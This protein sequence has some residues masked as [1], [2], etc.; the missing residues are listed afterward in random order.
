M[1]RDINIWK[2]KC[3]QMTM[4]DE[5]LIG[6]VF[7]FISSQSIFLLWWHFICF[8]SSFESQTF[9]FFFC[10]FSLSL[11]R[12]WRVSFIFIEGVT[13]ASKIE[14]IWKTTRA[15]TMKLFHTFLR[16]VHSKKL[17]VLLFLDTHTQH[18]LNFY[19]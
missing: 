9:F 15:F 3:Y 5:F 7:I 12:W 8:M 2:K 16:G 13:F 11:T 14:K 17:F 1:W 18:E 4:R 19:P 6:G 10:C